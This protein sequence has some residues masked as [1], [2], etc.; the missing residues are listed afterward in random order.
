MVQAEFY[1]G[2]IVEDQGLLYK[3]EN[4]QRRYKR[5]LPRAIGE[6]KGKIRYLLYVPEENRMG[7]I[8]EIHAGRAGGHFR[9]DK[10][11]QTIKTFLF[12]ANVIQ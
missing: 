10:T 6:G 4:V 9:A 1:N 12:L 7:L 3:V 8:K 2:I 5:E 11:H